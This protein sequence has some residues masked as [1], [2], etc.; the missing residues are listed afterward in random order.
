[1]SGWK[2]YPSMAK[3]INGVRISAEIRAEISAEVQELSQN[4][5]VVPGLAVVLVGENP[6]SRIYVRSKN[7]AARE[8]GIHSSQ[9]TLPANA[10]ET[11]LLR[12]LESL[13]A[14]PAVHGIL[15]QSPVP[16]H[17]NER[18]VN[19]AVDP[20][21]DV[22]G[23]HPMNL[24]R[25][26]TG[27]EGPRPCTPLGI[28][29]LLVRSGIGIEG[30]H[31]IVV[32]RS[33]LVGKPIAAML[34]QKAVN[35]DATVTLCHSSTRGLAALTRTADILIVAIGRPEFITADMV[36]EGAVVIDVGINRVRDAAREKGYR[37]VGDVKFDE[38]AS[39]CS[40]ITP[41]PGGVGPMTVTMLLYNTLRA[42]RG[43]SRRTA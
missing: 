33:N 19:A 15:V 25:I 2:E 17:I 40:A 20:A 31:V 35:A 14:D 22:D 41:V 30:S 24:G 38:V 34:S 8:L 42:A 32:G 3:I 13:N 18:R 28:Q 39:I 23:T 5:G 21:K 37:V 6:A 43:F 11:E 12:L 9:H 7:K 27:E 10:T 16:P 1:M 36:R 26:L 29:E 4:T